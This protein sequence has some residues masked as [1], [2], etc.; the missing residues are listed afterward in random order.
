MKSAAL[1]IVDEAPTYGA[2]SALEIAPGLWRMRNGHTARVE[3]L[4]QLPYGKG[5]LFPVWKGLCVECNEPKTWNINGTYAAV[6][7]H[8]LDILGAA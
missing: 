3:K 5:K 7:K 4:L 2:R 6:G 1:R 8:A